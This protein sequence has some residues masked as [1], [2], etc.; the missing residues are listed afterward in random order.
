MLNPVHIIRHW[1]FPH[2]SNNQRA[3]LLHPSSLTAV[4]LVWVVFQ[5]FLT[6]ASHQRLG[7]LGYASQISPEEVISLTN[8][9]RK[10]Q[11][12]G[13]VQLDESLSQAAAKKASDMFARDYW[14]HVSPIGTQPWFFITEAGYGYRY[15]GENLARDF[16]NA[17]DVVQAWMDSPT[18]RDN[19]LNSKYQDIGVAVVDGNLGGRETTLVVQMFGTKNVA[20]IPKP[21]TTTT[22]AVANQPVQVTVPV[23]APVAAVQSKTTITNLP[24]STVN[25]F[26]ITKVV[27]IGLIGLF[28]LV[29]VMD[30]VMI[31][32]YK[33][34]RWTSKSFAHLSLMVFLLIASIIV[35]VGRIL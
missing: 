25:P 1:L 12:L 23:E 7:I 26:D 20:A 16:T 11:G 31:N 13:T 32:R 10:T 24:V 4:M 35:G 27:G 34:M 2:E 14:A 17:P 9:R 28:V 22:S 6:V 3:K 18:H 21:K 33:V 5:V 8:E 15:A 30:V 29:L 19:L